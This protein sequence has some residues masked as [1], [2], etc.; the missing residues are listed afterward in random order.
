MQHWDTM[1]MP[2]RTGRNLASQLHT[3]LG[4][5]SVFACCTP[6]LSDAPTAF[7]RRGLALGLWRWLGLRDSVVR[8]GFVGA[9]DRLDGSALL[10]GDA[11][12]S[13]NGAGLLLGG[14]LDVLVG[15]AVRAARPKRED[16]P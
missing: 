14:I 13:P 8:V 2:C 1:R 16:K 15:G 10:L 11:Q 12:E 7:R 6:R 4:A 3:S 9:R 5:L